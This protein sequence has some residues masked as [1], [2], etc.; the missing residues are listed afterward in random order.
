MLHQAPG[1]GKRRG[2]VLIHMHKTRFLSLFALAGVVVGLVLLAGCGRQSLPADQEPLLLATFTPTPVLPTPTPIPTLPAGSVQ[3]DRF[4][5][6]LTEQQLADQARRALAAQGSTPVRDVVMDAQQ[7]RLWVQA[8]VVLGFLPV[9]VGLAVTA[10]PQDGRVQTTV[11][12]VTVNGARAGGVLRDQ[13][14][15]LVQPYLDSLAAVE[16]NVYV[17]SVVITD[18]QLEITG[19][20]R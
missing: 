12:E 18:S 20:R 19:R 8:Q 1:N 10:V 13:V 11:Q 6:V 2:A 17:D 7:G 16:Q 14:D 3:A 5:L 9:S 15:R 4:Q